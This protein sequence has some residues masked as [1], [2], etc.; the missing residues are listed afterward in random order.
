MADEVSKKRLDQIT[1]INRQGA[2]YVD[3]LKQ[4]QQAFK[5][6]SEAE[7][8]RLGDNTAYNVAQ[9][10]NLNVATQLAVLSVNDL[11]TR[12]K[13][14]ELEDKIKVIKGR[15]NTLETQIAEL[16]KEETAEAAKQAKIL[17]DT[18]DTSRDL[19]KEARKLTK[20]YSGLDN[21]AKMFDTMSDFVQDIPVINKLFPEFKNAAKAARDAFAEGDNFAKAFGK[22]L[23]ELTDFGLKG[24]IAMAV[25]GAASMQ[26][27]VVGLSRALGV[28]TAEATRMEANV[29]STGLGFKDTL[30][31][32]IA[33]QK[34]LGTSANIGA[35]LT[36]NAAVLQKRMGI[37]AENTAALFDAASLAGMELQ[38]FTQEIAGTVKLQNGLT[39]GAYNFLDVVESIGSASE[40]TRL[41]IGKF[42][43]GIASAAFET[44]KLGLSFSG[45]ESASGGL[46]DF[47]SSIQAELEAELLTGKQLNLQKAR[48][49][50]LKGDLAGVGEE[51]VKQLGS[52]EEF[53]NMNVLQRQAIAKA[54]GMTVEDVSKSFNI[55]RR[56]ADL[57]KL[58][59]KDTY[60][61]ANFEQKLR[62]L[63]SQGFSDEEAHMQLKKQLGEESYQQALLQETTQ[64]KFTQAMEKVAGL[65]AEHIVPLLEKYVNPALEWAS[66]N[67]ELVKNSFL[68]IA[69]VAI[70]GK[71]F[72]LFR[73]MGKTF[74]KIVG[75]IK[76]VKGF[77]GFGKAVAKEGAETVVKTGAKN[78]TKTGGK[79]AGKSLLKRVPILGSLMGLGFA[80]DRAIK[81][82][83]KGAA[84]EA[85]SGALG[86]LDLLAPGVGTALSLAADAGIAARDLKLAGTATTTIPPED[87]QLAS[88]GIVQRPTRALI[89]EAG[90][91]AVIPLKD[92]Y[93]KIDELIAEVKNSNNVYIDSRKVNSVLA[94]NAINQ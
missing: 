53:L 72:K 89:G 75:G 38:E 45:L 19:V 93:S 29:R 85:G 80:I 54:M 3:I 22:G 34:A 10:D 25:T 37:S 90:A 56:D 47:Q 17:K 67:A 68:G 61:N 27:R 59:A 5:E 78:L 88:G 36:E 1:E 49:L 77:F 7:Q 42:K 2:M 55:R 30:E 8:T 50:A 35:K 58:Q 82:D 76:K 48:E 40:T 91:E 39:G 71:L 46:L 66:K 62:L 69:G 32:T 12:G 64:E 63:K 87:P 16:L 73:F 4:Q 92:F 43:G 13:R 60:A 79:L 15:Q 70:G 26:D 65:L 20:T 11:K 74:T 33:F 86:L 44:R 18:L 24:V 57:A 94:M 31:S 21:V 23:L 84:M 51:I 81:G 9:K 14:K 52:E 83:F 6:L 41:T 28:S